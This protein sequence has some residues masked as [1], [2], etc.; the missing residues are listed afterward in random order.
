MKQ[1]ER[2]STAE[3]ASLITKLRKRRVRLLAAYIFHVGWLASTCAFA[4]ADAIEIATTTA[5][6][7]TLIT[8]PP[9]L[10]HAVSVHRACR[11]VDPKAN[12]VGLIPIVLATV[13]LT[14]FE[15]A[16]ILPAKN[17]LVSRRLLRAWDG[18][19]KVPREEPGD[20]W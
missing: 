4:A 17:L 9:V 2:R 10:F 1:H 5:L 13:F 11:A 20:C 12:S 18:R 14:P 6:W 16:L 3:M 8:V 19:L 15:S 7:L